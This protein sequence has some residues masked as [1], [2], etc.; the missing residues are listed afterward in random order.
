V[1]ADALAAEAISVAHGQR[2][3]PIVIGLAGAQGSGKST[4]APRLVERLS[5]SGLRARILALDDF[6]LTRAERAYLARDVH[7]LLA[8]RGVPGTHDTGLLSGILDSLLAGR[9]TEIPIFDKAADDRAGRR[10][11]ESGPD[12]ILLEGWCIGARPEPVDRLAAPINALEREEDADGAWRNWVNLRLA[13]DYAALFARLDLRL[14]LRAPSFDVVLGWR[15]EQERALLFGGMFGPAIKRF[16]DHYERI[17]RWMLEDE[18]ADLVI[19]LDP[20]RKP[21]LR[22]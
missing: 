5:A 11:I 21:T 4:M 6:Y 9:A 17:T 20:G 3:S 8:T 7:P 15:T 14:M 1:A 22:A 13:T 12:I 2:G 16:I 19:D 18:P 10:T